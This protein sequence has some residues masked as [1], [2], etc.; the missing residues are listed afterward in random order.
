[1]KKITAYGC[2]GKVELNVENGIACEVVTPATP[3]KPMEVEP[4]ANG[5]FDSFVEMQDTAE[6]RGHVITGFIAHPSYGAGYYVI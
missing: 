2:F 4:I 5:S 6:L 1:M 3:S